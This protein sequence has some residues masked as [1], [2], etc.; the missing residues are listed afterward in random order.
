MWPGQGLSLVLEQCFSTCGS[1]SALGQLTLSQGSSKTTR[2][3]RH[4]D[5]SQ[6]QNYS[7]EVAMKIILWLR[8]ITTWK[9]VLDR[10]SIRKVESHHLKSLWVQLLYSKDNHGPTDAQGARCEMGTGKLLE[11]CFLP[12][13]TTLLLFTL[14]FKEHFRGALNSNVATLMS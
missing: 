12:Q 6:K 4:Y 5:L 7:Y 14:R 10:H 9:T 13:N 1:W 3:H 2:R 8:V 11:S